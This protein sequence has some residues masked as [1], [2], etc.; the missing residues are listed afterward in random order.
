MKPHG[1]APSQLRHAVAAQ[2]FSTADGFLDAISSA[3]H[4]E[5]QRVY[6]TDRADTVPF[7]D[8]GVDY[9]VVYTP[10]I[11]F[12]SVFTQ[13]ERVMSCVC[14]SSEHADWPRAASQHVGQHIGQAFS[15]VPAAI[16]HAASTQQAQ[17]TDTCALVQPR[18]CLSFPEQ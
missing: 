14:S 2:D 4:R 15:D 13:G 18:T 1:G 6:S 3:W 5:W 7:R 11:K 12:W 9:Q 10:S 8:A 17:D 16:A